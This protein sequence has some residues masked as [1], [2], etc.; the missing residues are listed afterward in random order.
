MTDAGRLRLLEDLVKNCDAHI[1]IQFV[2]GRVRLM[3]MGGKTKALTIYA[4]NIKAA[5]EEL[6]K[7]APAWRSTRIADILSN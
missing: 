7:R 6:G 3:V 5:F 4:H 1:D 2:E